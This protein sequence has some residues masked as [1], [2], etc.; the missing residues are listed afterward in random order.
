M[1]NKDADQPH[2]FRGRLRELRAYALDRCP[3]GRAFAYLA[4]SVSR[5]RMC[6]RNGTRDLRAPVRR[7]YVQDWRHGCTAI[8]L[9]RGCHF[10]RQP[11]PQSSLLPRTLAV[12]VGPDARYQSGASPQHEP[13]RRPG[14]RLT[15]SP[16]PS[17]SCI[18]PSAP[19]LQRLQACPQTSVTLLA[20]TVLELSACANRLRRR[21]RNLSSACTAPSPAVPTSSKL[22]SG[23]GAPATAATR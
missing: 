14:W 4:S 22:G 23:I 10:A 8:R 3:G 17:V 19:G 12:I 20:A 5:N 9:T 16:S 18:I 7:C 15:F 13:R 1:L 2:A 21:L 11:A 6:R